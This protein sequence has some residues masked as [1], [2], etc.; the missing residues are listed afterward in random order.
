MSFFPFWGAAGFEELGWG[1]LL[2]LVCIVFPP[3]V[4]L[5]YEE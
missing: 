1:D 3:L 5:Q 4:V 2:G